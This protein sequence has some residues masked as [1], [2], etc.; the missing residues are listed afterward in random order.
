MGLWSIVLD[1]RCSLIALQHAFERTTV[2]YFTSETNINL[3]V[4]TK[5]SHSELTIGKVFEN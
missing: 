2:L 3:V 5:L 1:L 4:D